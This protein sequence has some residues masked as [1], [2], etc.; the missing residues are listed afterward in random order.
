MLAAVKSGCVEL[1]AAS[2]PDPELDE[3]QAVS[4]SGDR[5][6]GMAVVT[7]GG[8]DHQELVGDTPTGFAEARSGSGSGR[9]CWIRDTGKG[10][11]EGLR[12]GGV[13]GSG[14]KAR[15]G[16]RVRSTVG[17]RNNEGRPVSCH[18]QR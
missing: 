8:S 4:T 2:P 9:R 12:A 17:V 6:R 3:V 14:E 1:V 10:M 13:G 7:G 18:F 16:E 5:G 11:K 15:V